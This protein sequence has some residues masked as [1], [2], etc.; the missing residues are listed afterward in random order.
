MGRGKLTYLSYIINIDKYN[1]I[2]WVSEE[3]PHCL[4]QLVA[5]TVL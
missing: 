3:S 5:L 1:E 2:H 4:L